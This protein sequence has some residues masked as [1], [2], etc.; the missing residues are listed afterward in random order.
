MPDKLKP[1]KPS[2]LA[3][4]LKRL[5]D[6]RKSGKYDADEYEHRFARMVGELRDRSID[7]N[8]ADILAALTP[9][10]ADGTLDPG[11]WERLTRSLGLV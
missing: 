5:A 10:K 1:I 7:G 2:R 9:L 8:R 3:T 11:A 4:E 6:G